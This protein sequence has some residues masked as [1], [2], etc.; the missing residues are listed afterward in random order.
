MK[1]AAKDNKQ[2]AEEIVVNLPFGRRQ[3]KVL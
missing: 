1:P 2:L 3:P